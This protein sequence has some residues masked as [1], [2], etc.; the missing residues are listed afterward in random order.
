MYY[1]IKRSE[2]GGMTI[3]GNTTRI[4]HKY[5]ILHRE[6]TLD[7]VKLLRNVN[8]ILE[9]GKY[10]VE[11]SPNVYRIFERKYEPDGYLFKGRYTDTD[12]YFY[13]IAFYILKDEMDIKRELQIFKED[14]EVDDEEEDYKERVID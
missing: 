11:M 12:L 3:I 14:S 13:E 5:K 8:D 10:C 9:A 2:V 6:L 7:N 1:L 4:L